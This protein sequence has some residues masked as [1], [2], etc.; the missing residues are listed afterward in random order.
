[1]TYLIS[2][3]TS[4]IIVVLAVALVAALLIPLIPPMRRYLR[5]KRM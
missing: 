1:M 5:I 2:T 4:V 3:Q